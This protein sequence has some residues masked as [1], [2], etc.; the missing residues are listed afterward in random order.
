MIIAMGNT[1]GHYPSCNDCYAYGAPQGSVFDPLLFNLYT[2]DISKVVES[3]NHKLR[4]YA[5][6]CQVYLAVPVSEATSAVDH[7][8]H[9][10]E[11][12]ELQPPSSQ[13]DEDARHLVRRKTASYELQLQR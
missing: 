5:D 13:P 3:H 2:A 10:V 11:V 9:C 4:Q 1:K 7:F 6:D 8:S 12:V